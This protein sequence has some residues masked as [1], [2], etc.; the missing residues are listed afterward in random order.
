MDCRF[1]KFWVHLSFRVL[2]GRPNGLGQSLLHDW[3]QNDLWF[4][5]LLLLLL[6]LC[7]WQCRLWLLHL[8]LPLLLL[9]LLHLRLLFL[10]LRMLLLQD[11]LLLLLLL[12]EVALL[13][14]LLEHGMLW[15]SL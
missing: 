5:L 10:N 13:L 15:M 6:D 4:P 12:L 11:L 8:S 9:L 14:L 2:D 7:W 3:R 1:H